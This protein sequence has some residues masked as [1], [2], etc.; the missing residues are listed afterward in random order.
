MADKSISLPPR[1]VER[2]KPALL[3]GTSGVC[4]KPDFL[5]VVVG[6]TPLGWVPEDGDISQFV[7]NVDYGTQTRVSEDPPSVKRHR[8]SSDP[9]CG[10]CQ[11]HDKGHGTADVH[12]CNVTNGV[13]QIV[14]I[15]YNPSGGS[16]SRPDYTSE[17]RFGLRNSDSIQC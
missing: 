16:P 11:C 7:V 9:P 3:K 5:S 2:I 6:Y 1:R 8:R 13:V 17:R 14:G 12:D 10:T 4:P 15:P